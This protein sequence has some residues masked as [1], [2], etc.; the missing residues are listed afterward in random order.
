MTNE[1]LEEGFVAASKQWDKPHPANNPDEF[2][3]NTAARYFFFA[4]SEFGVD[5]T[6]GIFSETLGQKQ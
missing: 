6:K 5:I 2:L 1:Q 4:G 3:K